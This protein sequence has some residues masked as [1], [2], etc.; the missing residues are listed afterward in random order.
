MFIHIYME[1]HAAPA[2]FHCTILLL[3]MRNVCGF[4]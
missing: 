1:H 2:A 4:A 3:G